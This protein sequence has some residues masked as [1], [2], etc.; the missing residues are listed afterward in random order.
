MKRLEDQGKSENWIATARRGLAGWRMKKPETKAGQIRALW[1]EIEIALQDGQTLRSLRLW[2]E[3]EAGVN[4]TIETL[5]SYSN[6]FEKGIS[7]HEFRLVLWFSL[8]LSSPAS[9]TI[10]DRQLLHRSLAR[11]CD[12]ARLREQGINQMFQTIRWLLHGRP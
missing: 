11:R 8:K 9:Q 5:R 7:L 4:V 10:Q 1:P 12:H 6:V 3:E 2:L